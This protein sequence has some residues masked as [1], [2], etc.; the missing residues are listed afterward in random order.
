MAIRLAVLGSGSA[1]NAT[2]VEGGAARVLI[3]AGF[4][5]RE[6]AARLRGMGVE[7]QRLDGVL[8]THEHADHVR[9]AALFSRTYRV[10]VFCTAATARAS[11]LA[12]G[13]LWGRVEVTA[14]APFSIGG[15]S[16]HPFRL[17]HDAVETVGFVVEGRGHRVGYA[18]DLGHATPSV[19]E[20]LREC[21][22]LILESNHD[23]DMLRCGPYPPMVKQRVLGRHGHLDNESTASIA[24]EVAS[25]RTRLIVLAHLSRTNN[26][27][28]LAVRSMRLGFERAGR[29]PPALHAARQDAPSPWFEA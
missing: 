25:A 13:E 21:D 23:V 12:C 24:A 11:G 5:C 20:R 1:G 29:R 14:G 17:P 2:C 3:D 19:R 8:I 27:P 4:S 9:G 18:T 6:L 10:P 16:F 7:P 22:L 28:E 26:R 15:L